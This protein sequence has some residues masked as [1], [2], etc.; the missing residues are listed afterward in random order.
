[1]RVTS[2]KV[3]VR[4]LVFGL[5][6]G[7]SSTAYADT[8]VITSFSFGNLQFTPT[9]G[10]V[11][12]TPTG[13]SAR[14][15]ATNTFGGNQDISSNTFPVAQA[16]AS[17]TFA[18]ASGTASATNQTALVT[19]FVSVGDCTCAAS[20]FGRATFTGTFVITGGE[21]NVDVTISSMPFATGQVMTDQFGVFA[22][23]SI[24]WSLS[25]NGVPVFGTDE[26]LIGV[27]GPNQTGG[28]QLGPGALSKV[29]TLQ[30]GAVNTIAVNISAN[31]FGINAV[32]EPATVVLLVSGLGIMTGVL[33]KRRKKADR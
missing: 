14:A 32:P 24:A 3:F 15:L 5:L 8:V 33:K 20:A 2:L 16:A 11:A 7:T 30:Y 27:N 12:F 19:N 6:L 26:M 10:T 22:E 4:V 28:F 17:V 18:N 21:G 25:L 1:M 23:A 31:S 9:V 29:F 13:A